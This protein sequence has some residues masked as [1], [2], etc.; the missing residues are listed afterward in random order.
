MSEIFKLKKTTYA[1][2]TETCLQAISPRS[3]T[4]GL[5]SVSYLAPKIW[6]L[7]PNEI[8]RCKTLNSFRH[9]IKNWKPTACPC[10]LCKLYISNVGFI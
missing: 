9:S 10:R 3:T 6:N 7:V 2:R 1:L 5:D 8:K 4:Y